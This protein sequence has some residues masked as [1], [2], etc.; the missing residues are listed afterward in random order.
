MKML[1]SQFNKTGPA[2][3]LIQC[4]D[5]D[6]NGNCWVQ[7]KTCAEVKA[8]FRDI[9]IELSDSRAYPITPDNYLVDSTGKAPDS[10]DTI[11][12]CNILL[13]RNNVLDHTNEYVFG[14]IFMF[15][16]YLVFDFENQQ[17]GFNGRTLNLSKDDPTD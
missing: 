10:A 2:A 16:Y 17:I 12:Y 4:N 6:G 13:Q 11:N 1:D 5:G 8:G 7:G 9:M 14:T 15:N 3:G